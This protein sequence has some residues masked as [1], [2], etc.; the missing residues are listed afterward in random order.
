MGN[1]TFA[2]VSSLAIVAG[3]IG[4]SPR[5]MAQESAQATDDIIVT[6]QKR[7]ERLLDVPTAIAA[8]SGD[9]LQSRQI[10][11]ETDLVKLVPGL[12]V[13]SNFGQT[14]LNYTLRGIGPAG[15]FA[16][17]NA[18]PI[19][20]YSDE[21]PQAFTAASG[22]QFFDLERVEVLKGPQG[23]LYGRNTTGGLVNFI[24]RAPQLDGELNGRM[25]ALYGNRHK[26][27]LEAA[28]DLTIASDKLGARVAVSASGT[29]G[30]MRNAVTKETYGDYTSIQG[31]VILVGNVTD[32][33]D[34]QLKLF[35]N[36]V[37]GEASPGYF[38]GT[39]PGGSDLFGFTRA[40]FARNETIID[41]NP[42]EQNT[43]AYG[44]SLRVNWDAGPFD[45]VSVT[46]VQKSAYYLDGDCD[47]GASSLC[48]AIFD[49]KARQF[50][51]DLRLAYANDG[52]NLI[53]GAFYAQDTIRQ[54]QILS[55]LGQ[56][57]PLGLKLHNYFTQKRESFA[58]YADGAFDVTPELTV[59]A[60]VRYTWDT[61]RLTDTY[62]VAL[63]AYPNGN[64]VANLIPFSLVFDPN[65]RYPDQKRSPSA[66]TG[67]LV[68]DYK[69]SDGVMI[70]G[71]YSRG[72][73]QGA[74]NGQ[75]VTEAS[76][77]Y[78][79]PEKVH[80]FELGL[81]GQFF[82][83]ALTATADLF[84]LDITN[85]HVTSQINVNGTIAPSIAG[86]NG[87]SRGL[88]F[89]LSWKVTD[90]LTLR[91]GGSVL[92]TR[93]DDGQTVVGVSADG[94]RF[95]YAPKFA[96]QVGADWKVW[97]NDKAS[98]TFS[99]DWNYTGGY[100]YNPEN[101]KASN[102]R[103]LN[104]GSPSYWLGN[105]RVTVG[106]GSIQLSAWVENLTDQFYIPII[107]DASGLTF[108][109]GALGMPRSYG[110]TLKTSF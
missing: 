5:A 72:Y 33:L 29:D 84:Y 97:T 85:Q 81:K 107:Q 50:T 44:T 24:S 90:R 48:L 70:Y 76:L 105:A 37:R 20:I 32:D 53:A 31:R 23:T 13:N 103:F 59:T 15:Q 95:P 19:G 56:L 89:D 63:D 71:S 8:L 46:G 39:L 75:A 101:G 68:V 7:E 80:A 57:G 10:L 108:N 42:T 38:M 3:L 16:S 22:V 109:Y 102:N 27:A 66:L 92:K 98:V 30:Y 41:R 100:F 110:V 61:V 26:Y 74:F 104:R 11:M 64:P 9:Q 87:Y 47:G 28:T 45:I 51:Q 65:L 78:V 49:T 35:G 60:G 4:V 106:F 58:V 73:R 94:N 77:T 83:R 43:S 93:Y 69:I 79:D 91:G 52:V 1:R 12:Q 34:F 2:R 21:I 55:F 14:N 62:A 54:S 88:E 18:A 82:D 17:S 36:R 99:T 86:L 96:T 6:A 40:N 25:S 67:R